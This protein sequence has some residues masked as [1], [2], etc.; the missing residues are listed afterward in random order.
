MPY[1]NEHAA[2][3]REPGQFETCRRKDLGGGVTL[4]V[5]KMKGSTQWLSQSYR[6]KKS[7]FTPQQARKW[8]ADNN[9]KIILFEEAKE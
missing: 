2:R 7:E 3:V 8:M 5:C 9:E 6:F 4:I 1:E